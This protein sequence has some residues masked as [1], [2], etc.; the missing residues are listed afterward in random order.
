[1]GGGAQADVLIGDFGND[2]F[3]YDATSESIN[4]TAMSSAQ[5]RWPRSR[6]SRWPAAI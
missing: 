2:G 5:G 1:L 3:D 4:A 6:A